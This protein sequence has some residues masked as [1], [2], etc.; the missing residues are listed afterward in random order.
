MIRAIDEERHQAEDHPLW[1]ESHYFF[2]YDGEHQNGGFIRIGLQ[3]T[4]NKSN[5]WC[6]LIRRGRKAYKRLL[7]DLPL[8][9]A[10]LAEGVTAGGATV[11]VLEPLKRVRLAF[12]D[13]NTNLDLVFDAFHPVKQLGGGGGGL[14]LPKNMAS[15]HYEQCHVVRGSFCVKGEQFHFDGTGA[16]DHSWGIRDWAGLKGWIAVWPVFGE[17]LGFS[18]GRVYVPQGGPLKLGFLY[19]GKQNQEIAESALTVAFAEDGH[20]P[21]SAAV[22]LRGEHGMAVDITGRLIANFA[23]GFDCNIL[24]EAMFEYRWAERVGYGMCEHFISL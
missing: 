4:V 21:L 17:D 7:F 15:S 3:E 22:T 13:G 12:T 2:F 11:Q 23:L 19:D 5:V 8:D 6:L 24:N 10:T 18:C 20:T 14:D 16:R 1:S 9:N